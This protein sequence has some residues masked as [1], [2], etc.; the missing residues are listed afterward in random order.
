MRT[1]SVG[2]TMTCLCDRSA[3]VDNSRIAPGLVITGFSSTGR[4]LW[5]HA[6]NSGISSNG[7]TLARHRLLSSEYLKKYPEISDPAVPADIA[8]QGNTDL[9]T[10]VPGLHMPVGEALLSPTRTYAPFLVALFDEVGPARIT[11]LVNNTGGGLTKSLNFGVGI[12][13]VK[14]SP[15]AVPPL[16]R[17]IRE[18][19]AT[20]VPWREMYRVF[21]MGHRLELISTP[22]VSARAIKIADSFRLEGKVIG[23]TEGSSDGRNRVHV[24]MPD[25]T[26][27][28]YER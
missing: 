24:T 23:R 4:T 10:P 11:G 16:F 19:G 12:T 7:F 1:I 3:I 21:N 15:F 26:I 2:A 5:E 20:P 25:G 6:P 18:S 8:Y 9:D 14:D 27:E 22:E 17:M 28:H 13:Y